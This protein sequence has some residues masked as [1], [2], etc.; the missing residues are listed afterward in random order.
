[1][2]LICF[3]SIIDKQS[4]FGVPKANIIWMK[5]IRECCWG[6]LKDEQIPHEQ[7]I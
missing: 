2:A 7:S 5:C 6:R 1:M 4:P 3:E